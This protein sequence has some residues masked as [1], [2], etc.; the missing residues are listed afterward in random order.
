MAGGA[1]FAITVWIVLTCLYLLFA[2]Q[3]S[4]SE[5]IA[6]MPAAAMATGVA[7][8][9]RQA[10]SRPLRLRAPWPRVIGRPLVSLFPDA[11]RVARVL[12]A[13]LWRRPSGAVGLVSRQPFRHGANDAANAGRRGLVTLGLS[14][15]PNGYVLRLPDRQDVLLMHRLAPAEPDSDTEWPA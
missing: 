2:G 4:V 6:G 11:V 13:A 12:L 15:A 1:L 10:R 3:L 7:V 8:V 5:M 9:W 14:L